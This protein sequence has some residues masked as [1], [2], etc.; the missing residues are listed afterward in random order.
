M[1]ALKEERQRL[2]L[3]LLER[4]GRV[5]ASDLSEQWELSED[6]IRRDLR[7]MADTGLIQRVHGGALRRLPSPPPFPSRRETDVESKDEIARAAA[8]L[9]GEDSLV[10]IDGGT[11]TL[12]IASYLARDRRATIATNSPPLA[13]ALTGHLR[14][15]VLLLGGTLLKD[16]QVTVG[17][18]TVRGIE[19]L[20]ADLCLL[21]MC[22]L[23]SRA[24]I[25]AED[26]DE[27]QTKRAM[28]DTSAE[29]IGL[30]TRPKMETV[31][32]YSVGRVSSLTEI[33]TDT[34]DKD[35]LDQYASQGVR[36]RRMPDK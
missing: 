14:L 18:E 33:I 36:I 32:G 35:L 17:I 28:I 19:A 5:L 3:N 11:T 9:I 12:Q 34:C 30:I 23:H 6:T 16:S 15:K 8:D 27:A 1:Y 29:V 13:L 31:L 26:G 20:H 25:T 21:G 22:A 7:E 4:N 10:L 2:I 24:G